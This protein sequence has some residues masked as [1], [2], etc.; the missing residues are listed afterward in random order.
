[1]ADRSIHIDMKRKT[2]TDTVA[3][4][5]ATAP[6]VFEELRQ[7]IIRFVNDNTDSIKAIDP[8]FPP[9]LNDRAEDCWRPL[10]TVAEVAGNNWPDLARR[11]AVAL[12]GASDDADTFQTKL[13]QSLKQ[14]F[15]DKGENHKI[16]ALFTSDIIIELNSD[17][18]APWQRLKDRMTA[19]LLARSLRPYKVKSERIPIGGKRKRGF[20]WRELDPVLNRYL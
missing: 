15:E 11:A 1:M 8:S 6:G 18:E 2:K 17:D 10:L 7:K 9:G 5:R 3:K 20:L 19:E 12:S 16:G 14:I 4:L 13:L